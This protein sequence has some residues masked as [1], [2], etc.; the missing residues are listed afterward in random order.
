M[1]HGR[2]VRWVER[3]GETAK[4]KRRRRKGWMLLRE[5]PVKHGRGMGLPPHQQLTEHSTTTPAMDGGLAHTR[6]RDYGGDV[7]VD[8][9]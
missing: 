2:H 1:E 9:G 4:R 7:G 3:G 6:V 5:R 8:G